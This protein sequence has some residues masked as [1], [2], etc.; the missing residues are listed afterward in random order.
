MALRLPTK[1]YLLLLHTQPVLTQYRSHWSVQRKQD[2]ARCSTPQSMQW[3]RVRELNSHFAQQHVF[4]KTRARQCRQSTRLVHHQQVFV[5]VNQ[6]VLVWRYFFEPA[7]SVPNQNGAWP[8]A[9]VSRGSPVIDLHLASRQSSG[10]L[11]FIGMLEKS[12]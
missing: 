4:I 7:W 11:G 5:L 1:G 9:L 12:Y 6:S 2:Q 10:P 3:T 8:Q